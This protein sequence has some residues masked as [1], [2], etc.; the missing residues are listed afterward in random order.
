MQ[1]RDEDDLVAAFEFVRALAFQLPIRIIDEDEDTGSTG[2][3][4]FRASLTL[5]HSERGE[6]DVHG[7][8]LAKELGALGEDVRAQMT[9]QIGD[10]WRSCVRVRVACT[11]ARARRRV[12]ARDGAR[13]SGGVG[14]MR[15]AGDGRGEGEHVC[16]L[17]PKQEL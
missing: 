5:C 14:A 9:D 1:G 11:R 3:G 15:R 10:V 6:S 16:P 17:V 7:V 13:A 8:A 12:W 4:G 2:G